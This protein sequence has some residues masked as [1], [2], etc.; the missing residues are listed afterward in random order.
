MATNSDTREKMMRELQAV[1]F[2]LYDTLLYLD[3]HPDDDEA[4]SH[5]DTLSS[6][7]NH[8]MAEISDKYGAVTADYVVPQNGFTW[9]DGPWPWQEV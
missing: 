6:R 2:S 8:L 1:S 5:Y 4:L 3:T 9:I 7:R